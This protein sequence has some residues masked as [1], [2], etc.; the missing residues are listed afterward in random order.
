MYRIFIVED[1]AAIASTLARQIQMWGYEVRCAEHFQ[2][3][4]SR[5]S[6]I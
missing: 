5:I 3:I 1:D 4:L 6:G 2:D